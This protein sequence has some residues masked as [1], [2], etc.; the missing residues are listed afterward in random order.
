MCCKNKIYFVMLKRIGDTLLP[1]VEDI[2]IHYCPHMKT[3]FMQKRR[4]GF[5][6]RP[7][8]EPDRHTWSGSI[9]FISR[10]PCIRWWGTV[11]ASTGSCFPSLCRWGTNSASSSQS[12]RLDLYRTCAT[13]YLFRKQTVI[14]DRYEEQWWMLDR[15][16]IREQALRR[17][18]K[19]DLM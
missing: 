9:P 10:I 12:D 11:L 19:P 6:S 7:M 1:M 8:L 17:T 4:A 3:F 5:S 14:M 13:P 15:L 16:K 18:S 2:L